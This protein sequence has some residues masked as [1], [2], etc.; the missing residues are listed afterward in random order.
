MQL[1]DA[2]FR[3]QGTGY[4]HAV[5]LAAAEHLSMQQMNGLKL[6]VC[7]R[8]LI[9]QKISHA[10]HSIA[11]LLRAGVTRHEQEAL[12]KHLFV[13]ELS[14][15]LLQLIQSFMK[16]LLQF[17]VPRHSTLMRSFHECSVGL[18]QLRGLQ[19]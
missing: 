8:E 12:L 1:C 10:H 11:L 9:Y 2:H 19:T 3:L 14:P 16:L 15:E 13:F 18:L 7:S 4:M 17:S 6:Q 5:K